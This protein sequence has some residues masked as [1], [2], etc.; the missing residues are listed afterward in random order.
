MTV[1]KLFP[2]KGSP[3][4]LTLHNALK[5]DSGTAVDCY[6]LRRVVMPVLEGGELVVDSE[7]CDGRFREK[8]HARQLCGRVELLPHWEPGPFVP[9]PETF[10]V[11]NDLDSTDSDEEDDNC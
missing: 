7:T 3:L 1:V 10:L 6:V 11:S 2:N 5:I 4:N 8:L 9:P